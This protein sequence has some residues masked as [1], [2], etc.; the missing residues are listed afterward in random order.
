MSQDDWRRGKAKREYTL[1]YCPHCTE[2]TKQVKVRGDVKRLCQ[3]CGTELDDHR[4]RKN[5][6]DS[7]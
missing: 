5:E 4:V 1:A 7:L 6:R 2:T 3:K